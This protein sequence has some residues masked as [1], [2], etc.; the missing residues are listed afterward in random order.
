MRRVDQAQDGGI[1]LELALLALLAL[2]WGSSYLFIRIAVETIPPITL[3]AFRVTIAAVLLLGL[4]AW[5]GHRLPKDRRTW[6][7]LGLQA[8]LNSFGAWTLLAWGQQYVE[9]GLAG[10]LNSTSPIFVFFLTLIVTRHES[11]SSRRLLGAC[12]GLC[13]VALIMG[14]D[15]LEGLGQEV[16]AQAAVLFAA[17]LYALAAIYGKRFGHLPA[18]VTAASAMLWSCAVLIPA[19][20]LL[21]APWRLQPAPEAIAAV[22]ALGVFCT[23]G[24]LLIYFRLVRTLGSIG[25][26]SQSYLRSGVSV[27]LGVLILGESFSPPIAVGLAAAILGVLLINWPSRRR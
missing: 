20:L 16:L 19:S 11:L 13:G 1:A 7:A 9:S 25:V 14:L 3:I 26:T 5:K 17:F 2:F 22:M 6:L 23:A 8:F 21:E 4:L 24:A 10:V 27:L 18:S 12:L 15:V